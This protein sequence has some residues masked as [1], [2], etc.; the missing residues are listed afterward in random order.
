MELER[1]RVRDCACP[2]TP[3]TEEGDW[4]SVTPTLS[5]EGGL[6]AESDLRLANQEATD[7]AE[8]GEL[9][10]R[11]WAITFVR[12]GAKGWNLVNENGGIPFSIDALLADYGLARAVADRCADLYTEAVLRPFQKI[13]AA[14]SPTG[15][16]NGTTSP[17]R[18]RTRKSPVS[19][20][21][22][23]MAA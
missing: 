6:A 13:L 18:R 22:D 17:P 8:R 7:P 3:H 2:N 14:R 10:Q 1:V 16:T 5:L 15:P 19:S 11:R 23:V 9:I 20:S 12:Y 21:P 4:V